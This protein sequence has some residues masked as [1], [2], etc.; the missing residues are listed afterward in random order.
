MEGLHPET[1]KA[2]RG[3]VCS[4]LLGRKIRPGEAPQNASISIKDSWTFLAGLQGRAKWT[5]KG[6]V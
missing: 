6:S 5:G 4:A 2:R 1:R 3:G